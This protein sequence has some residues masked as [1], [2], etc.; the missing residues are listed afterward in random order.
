LEQWR[1]KMS[2]YRYRYVT[3]KEMTFIY[4]SLGIMW[5]LIAAGVPT[6]IRFIHALTEGVSVKIAVLAALGLI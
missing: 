4:L 3:N 2:N 1:K 5:V 6:F